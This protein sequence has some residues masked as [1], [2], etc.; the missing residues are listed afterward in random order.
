MFTFGQTIRMQNTLNSLRAVIPSANRCVSTANI[1]DLQEIKFG[2]YPI[3]AQEELNLYLGNNHIYDGLIVRIMNPF[4][5]IM[6]EKKMTQQFESEAIDISS[7]PN[8]SYIIE[9]RNDTVKGIKKFVIL[10]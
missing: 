9:L 7:I 1:K 5:Q 2:I 8:G 10:R 3:P 4:G 6:I